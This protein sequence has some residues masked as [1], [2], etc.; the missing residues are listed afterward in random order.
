MINTRTLESLST[1]CD[2][3]ADLNES[4]SD[5]ATDDLLADIDTALAAM[6]LDD[7]DALLP[8]IRRLIMTA[9]DR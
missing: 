1:I 9:S 7:R 4:T 8:I 3:I 5:S 6:P 2:R